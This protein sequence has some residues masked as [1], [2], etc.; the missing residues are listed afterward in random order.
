MGGAN[1]IRNTTAMVRASQK[2]VKKYSRDW[3]DL[4]RLITKLDFSA[5]FKDLEHFNKIANKL[6]MLLPLCKRAAKVFLIFAG[7][8]TLNELLKFEPANT[9]KALQTYQE[10]LQDVLAD[11]DRGSEIYREFAARIEEVNRRLSDTSTR[12]GVPTTMYSKPIGPERGPGFFGSLRQSTRFR[13]IATGAGFPLLFG[14]GPLQALGGGIGGGLGGLG[15][16]IA[17][18]AII[19]QLEAFGRAAAE[20]GVK[21]PA[22]PALLNFYARSRF[23]RM[24]PKRRW[25]LNTSAQARLEN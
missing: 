13:D 3:N 25:R 14:G 1:A 10:V 2:E 12:K 18:S 24:K 16:A 23:L 19:S 6:Q 21:V 8:L 7:K 4:Q 11:V 5:A 17:G 20:V 22:P 9:T 15:G